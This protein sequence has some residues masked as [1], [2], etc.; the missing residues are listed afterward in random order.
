MTLFNAADQLSLNF[1]HKRILGAAKGFVS[2]G[3][4]PISALGGFLAPAPARNVVPRTETARPSARGAAGQELGRAVKFAQPANFGG[5]FLPK[6]TR[7]TH[8]IRAFTTSGGGGE[9]PGIFSVRGP[10]GTCIDLTALPPGGRPALTPQQPSFGGAGGPP[11][12][13]VMGRYGAA[14]VPGS[15]IIDR[16]ECI[17]GMVVGNDGLCYNKSQIKNADRM[18]PKGRRPLLT[19]GDMAAISKAA[20]AAG[21]LERTTKRLQ[22]IGL[23]KRPAKGASRRQIA[24]EIRTEMH[25]NK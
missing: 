2:S 12:E 11:G 1:V 6:V 19:G 8:P 10:G 16:A 20:R 7:T 5:A 14:L 24:A 22:K 3:F 9:C 17:R 18:W 15:R 4:N 21:R 13:A 25:H 23:M